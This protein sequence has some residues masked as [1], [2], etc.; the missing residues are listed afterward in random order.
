LTQIL[1]SFH[2]AG[3]TAHLEYADK[4]TLEVKGIIRKISRKPNNLKKEL[5]GR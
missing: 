2:K 5:A 4:D 1:S 3:G